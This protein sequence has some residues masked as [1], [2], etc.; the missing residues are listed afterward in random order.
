MANG[1]ALFMQLL[2]SP[3]GCL[4]KLHTTAL[5]SSVIATPSSLL[6]AVLP[7]CPA[8]VPRALQ[9]SPT[10]LAPFASVRQV[11]TFHARACSRFAPPSSRMPHGPV[12]RSPTILIPERPPSPVSTS[13]V[14]FRQF[15]DGSLS[16][17]SLKL[18]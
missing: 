6:R 3:V 5:R 12:F 15:I 2:P 13:T 10:R 14:R 4:P 1:F 11:L 8:S 17:V 9:G 18:T 16:L 7:L